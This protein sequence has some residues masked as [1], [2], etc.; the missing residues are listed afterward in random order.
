MRTA[1]AEKDMKE[2]AVTAAD[3]CVKLVFQVEQLLADGV[4]FFSQVCS[5]RVRFLSQ[6][7]RKR[8]L[9]SC[10]FVR[11]WTHR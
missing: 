5:K 11:S 1:H 9:V 4:A 7:K 3:R 10:R 2:V 8:S 6:R